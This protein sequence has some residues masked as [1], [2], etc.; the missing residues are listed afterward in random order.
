MLCHKAFSA[1]CDANGTMNDDD[2][3]S[4]PNWPLFLGSF[5]VLMT[6]LLMAAYVHGQL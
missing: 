1:R 3:L 5:A 6:L 2:Q 4:P